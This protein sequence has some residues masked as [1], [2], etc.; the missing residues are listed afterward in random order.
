MRDYE[1]TEKEM[2]KV[3][4][5]LIDVEAKS[6]QAKIFVKAAERALVFLPSEVESYQKEQGV[7]EWNVYVSA[8]AGAGVGAASGKC[9]SLIL[10]SNFPERSPSHD[11][12][13][14]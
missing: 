3:K 2:G 14:I 6:Q 4:R 10:K 1:L 7:N 8:A 12:Q 11:F 5:L 9:V 13:K